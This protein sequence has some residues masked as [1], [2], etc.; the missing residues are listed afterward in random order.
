MLN[1]VRVSSYKEMTKYQLN[2]VYVTMINMERH[3]LI[4]KEKM[5]EFYLRK[6]YAKSSVTEDI[7]SLCHKTYV[8]HNLCEICRQHVIEENKNFRVH[9]FFLPK[10]TK[11]E[12]KLV[13]NKDFNYFQKFVDYL[14][15]DVDKDKMM[16]SESDSKF[17]LGL[18]ERRTFILENPNFNIVPQRSEKPPK[19]KARRNRLN[20][21]M[22]W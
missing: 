12:L 4:T 19:K 16:R 3:F 17:V 21:Y 5:E 2:R 20:A 6:K 22:K 13:K 10:L 15:V 1:L 7:E 18:C 11:N 8:S 14:R 9:T